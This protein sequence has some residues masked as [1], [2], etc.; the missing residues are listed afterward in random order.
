MP[1]WEIK[2]RK[3][4]IIGKFVNK[5]GVGSENT[6]TF[7]Q[8]FRFFCRGDLE[9]AERASYEFVEDI[10]KQDVVYCEVRFSP[11]LWASSVQNPDY[12]E[13]GDVTPRQAGTACCFVFDSKFRW[14][15]PAS[16]ATFRSQ[17]TLDKNLCARFACHVV[18]SCVWLTVGCGSCDSGTKTRWKPV[19]CQSEGYFMLHETQTRWVTKQFRLNFSIDCASFSVCSRDCLFSCRP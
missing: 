18:L 6:K 3:L 1:H 9:A 4:D 5:L 16:Q 7:S 13:R 8:Q 10:A 14:M 12:C 17:E 19:W 15:Y 11:H 2:S